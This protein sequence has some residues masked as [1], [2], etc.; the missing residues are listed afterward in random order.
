MLCSYYVYN[1]SDSHLSQ[2]RQLFE[3]PGCLKHSEFI[4]VQTPEN[5]KEK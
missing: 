2:L 1:M 5:R 3:D 4:V